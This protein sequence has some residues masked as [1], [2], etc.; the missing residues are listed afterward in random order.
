MVDVSHTI[1][2]GLK[3][4][5]LGSSASIYL[6]TQ[7]LNI[8]GLGFLSTNGIPKPMQ[9]P[10][11]S[12]K[13]NLEEVNFPMKFQPNS[14]QKDMIDLWILNFVCNLRYEIQK[15]PLLEILRQMFKS[16]FLVSYH[17]LIKSCKFFCMDIF[18]KALQF[19]S[20]LDFLLI[21]VLCI[22]SL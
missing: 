10:L 4:S 21:I 15:N 9:T 3:Q 20:F 22:V 11:G 7:Q 16:Q 19:W 12:P 6:A 18:V 5:E 1:L 17:T 2:Y 13:C 14:H 8:I